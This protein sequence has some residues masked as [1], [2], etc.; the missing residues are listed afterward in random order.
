MIFEEVI[1]GVLMG[2]VCGVYYAFFKLI[3]NWKE[4]ENHSLFEDK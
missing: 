1:V 2:L 4:K 3:K